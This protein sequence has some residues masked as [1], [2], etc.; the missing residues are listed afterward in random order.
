LVS[1]RCFFY[2]HGV[3]GHWCCP[4]FDHPKG[5]VSKGNNNLQSAV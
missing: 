1:S 2:S 4:T 3:N 5:Y